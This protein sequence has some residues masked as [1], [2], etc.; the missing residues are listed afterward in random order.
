M[1]I[2]IPYYPLIVVPVAVA[3]ALFWRRGRQHLAVLR[4][5]RPLDRFDRIPARI[6]SVLV[7]VI[8]QK[9][10]LNDFG[11]GIMHAAIFWGFLVLL[12][13]T[14]NYF[15]NGLVETV[16]AWPLNGILWA[17]A[18]AVAN[19]FIGLILAALVYAA[20]R[21]VI[22]RP[23]RLALSRDAFVIL[24]LIFGVVGTELVADALRFV[25]T[26]DDPARGWALLA[27]PLSLALEPI[28]AERAASGFGLLGWAHIGFV[29]GFGAYLPY[30]KHLHIITSEP[31]VY[32]RS[33]EPRGALRKMDLE[34]EPPPGEEVVFG[35]RGLKDLTWRHLLDGLSCTECG[36]CMEFCPASM[37]GKTLS[38]KHFMEGLRDQIVMAETALAAAASAQRAAKGGAPGGVEASDASLSLA[39]ERATEALA[40]P[41]V[42]NAIP[43]EA[44]W[45]CTTCGWCVEGCPVL[46]EHVDSIVEIRRN[47]VLEESR[48]P[49]ELNVA[50]RNMETAG[51]PWGQAKSSRLDW[52]KG[53]EIPVL[54]QRRTPSGD[55]PAPAR[56]GARTIWRD[57]A[58][59]DGPILYWVGCAG[60]FDDRNRKVVRAM[61]ALLGQAGIDFA[62]LGPAETC[63]G[64]PARR[65]GNEYLFQMLAA[66]NVATLSAAHDKHGV[67]TIVASCPHCFNTIR[68]EYP[69]F[70]LAGIEVI[71]HTQL[72]DR[73]VADGRLI[74]QQHHE[75]VVAYHDA[76]YLGR[77]NQVYDEGRRVVGAVPGTSVVEME[78]HH[79]RG[80]CCGAGGARMWMEEREGERVN[81]RRVRQA[82]AADP[83]TIATACPFCLVMLRDGVTDL[84]RTDVEV[85]D[86]AEL[87]AD[88]TGVWSALIPQDR[89]ESA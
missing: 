80:M 1:E 34:A 16:L 8:G 86:V 36:R 52:A 58:P 69:Q 19:L 37:T 38:P 65:A 87:L 29:L 7:Y 54:G 83:A 49:K 40:L 30:S 76:C 17:A 11:P 81:H 9:R 4:A 59:A 44:V 57:G 2:G 26:P 79:R 53:L 56:R 27:G 47:L 14:G 32:F 22:A 41:L 67:R 28:G 88:A 33:L 89:A 75:A 78:L 68:N 84:E 71:H 82:L 43:E 21:R 63:S 35:A 39:R 50:F 74:P 66:E 45:Q 13:T 46:I 15:T 5:G 42:D 73:L 85:R 48:F 51:N 24:G 12:V 20:W 61:A 31:N 6:W 60:A 18:V 23:P 3:V 10:L 55:G 25:A 72:L 64:D 70:G 77:Y 62:V